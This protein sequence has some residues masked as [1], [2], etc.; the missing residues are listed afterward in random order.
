MTPYLSNIV[1]STE[2]VYKLLHWNPY[3][4]IVHIRDAGDFP[5]F[6]LDKQHCLA[7]ES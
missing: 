3:I 4:E 5:N 6:H 7:H 2:G 1:P